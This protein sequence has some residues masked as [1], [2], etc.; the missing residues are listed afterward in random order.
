MDIMG[1]NVSLSQSASHW[2]GSSVV[3]SASDRAPLTVEPQRHQQQL[4]PVSRADVPAENAGEPPHLEET[5]AVAV[6]VAMAAAALNS[7]NEGWTLPSRP[8]VSAWPFG[9]VIM[10]RSAHL[11][12]PPCLIP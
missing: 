9:H 2:G 7:S 10:M 1:P 11:S 5:T 8:L 3:Q 6:A 4:R 12:A